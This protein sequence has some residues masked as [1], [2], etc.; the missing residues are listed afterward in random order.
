MA[1]KLTEKER[2]GFENIIEEDLGEIDKA[3]ASQIREIWEESRNRVSKKLGFDK[4]EKRRDDINREIASLN[5]EIEAIDNHQ[6]N[7]VMTREQAA[8]FGGIKCDGS[9]YFDKYPSFHGIRLKS[10]FDYMVA[11][12]VVKSINDF[13]P[14]KYLHDLARACKRELTMCGTFEDAQSLY[15]KLYSLDFRKY[16]VDI[17]PKLEEMK[18]QDP[19]LPAPPAPKPTVMLEAPKK[20]ARGSGSA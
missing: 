3:V 14:A 1:T 12:D 4:M 5:D 8:E 17:P 20:R 16:G 6:H 19:T 7:Q 2:K 13:A 11:V 10:Q 9:S 15:E 18:P